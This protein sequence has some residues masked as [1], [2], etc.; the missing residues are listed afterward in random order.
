MPQAARQANWMGFGVISG[1]NRLYEVSAR[2]VPHWA[3]A[4]LLAILPVIWLRRTLRKK[5]NRGFELVNQP[6]LAPK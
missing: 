5:S 2:F 6:E 3:V 1:N 4:L